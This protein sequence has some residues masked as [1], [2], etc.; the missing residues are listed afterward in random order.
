[1]EVNDRLKKIIFKKLANDLSHVEV[2]P[3]KGSIWFIDRDK[4]YWYL[5]LENDGTLW[6]R[7]EIFDRFFQAFS[8]EHDDYEPIIVEWVEEILNHRVNT[9]LTPA[10]V[11]SNQVEEVLNHKVNTIERPV[12]LRYSPV[13]RILNSN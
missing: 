13:E 2:I 10:L 7:E 4:K 11:R 5:E 6:Y 8:L 1:M 12:F 3:Y 9:I